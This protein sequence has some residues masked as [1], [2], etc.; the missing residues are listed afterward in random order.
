MPP[1]PPASHTRN[2]S[3]LLL[4]TSSSRGKQ[5]KANAEQAIKQLEKQIAPVMAVLLDKDLGK[6][7]NYRQLPAPSAPLVQK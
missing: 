7:L 5:Q 6:L 3:R 1:A 2:K 4:P